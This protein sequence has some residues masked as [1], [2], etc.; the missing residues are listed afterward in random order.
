MGP[1]SLSVLPWPLQRYLIWEVQIH[2][3][4]AN[5]TARAL[6][7]NS[8]DLADVADD[9]H[10]SEAILNPKQFLLC[11]CKTI[12]AGFLPSMLRRMLSQQG[13]HSYVQ[14]MRLPS[15]G[16][17]R[18]PP[19][20]LQK[21]RNLKTLYVTLLRVLLRLCAGVARAC[22]QLQC[23]SC[24]STGSGACQRTWICMKVQPD[25]SHLASVPSRAEV[26]ATR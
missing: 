20:Y 13:P 2:L 21:T 19:L 14:L 22:Q 4:L 12:K 16:H 1:L 24:H 3:L 8:A 7:P 17:D 25:I 23:T 26:V 11:P 10:T 6:R 9:Y 18:T 5:P 15:S